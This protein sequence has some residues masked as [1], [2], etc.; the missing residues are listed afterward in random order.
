MSDLD[1]AE[2]DIY[3]E[4]H[5]LLEKYELPFTQPEID[6]IFSNCDFED[7]ISGNIKREAKGSYGDYKGASGVF[8]DDGIDDLFT[9]DLPIN[10]G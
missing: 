9:V 8:A 6:S 4:I 2:G 7:I 3:S 1:N 5:S 10:S